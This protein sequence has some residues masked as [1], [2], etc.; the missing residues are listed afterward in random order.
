MTTEEGLNREIPPLAGRSGLWLALSAMMGA[1]A[2][3]FMIWQHN[4]RT[5]ERHLRQ[6]FDTQV[7]LVRADLTTR[8]AGYTQTLRGA[9]AL[10]AA[11]REVSREEWR[12]Y[13]AGLRLEQNYP[14]IQALAFARSVSDDELP[15]LIDEVRQSGVPDFAVRPPGRRDRY[16]VNVFAEPYTGLNPKALGYD[17]WQDADRRETMERAQA[18]GEPMITTRTTL[19]VDDQT[20]PVPAF[21]M[22]FPVARKPGGEVFGYVLSPFRMPALMKDWLKHR[23]GDISLSIHDGPVRSPENLYYSSHGDA[24]AAGAR[25]VHEE[26]IVVGGRPWT[27]RYASRPQLEVHGNVGALAQVLAGGLLSSLLLFATIWSLAGTRDR[28]LRLAREMTQSLR[29]SEERWKFALEGAGDGVWDWNIQTGEALFSRRWKEM[30]GFAENEIGNTSSEWSSRVHPED[31]P[32]AMAAVQAHIDGKTPSA[33]VEFRMR[34]KDGSWLWTLGRGMVVSRDADGRAVRLVGTNTDIAERKRAEQSLRIAAITF[35]CQEGMMITDAEQ[36]ILRVNQA[37]TEITGYEGE[38]VIGKTPRLLSSGRHD[39]TFY[40][41]M[42]ESIQRS[43]S[44]RG[45]I[46]NR[47]KGGEVYPEWLSITAVKGG[48][49]NVT[50]YVGTFAD[51]TMRKA[52]EEEIRNLAFYDPL[53]RLPNRRLMF[54]RLRQALSSSARRERHG[55]LIL[56]DLDD[57]KT[58]NDTLGH[59]VGDKF[60][61][62]VASRIQACIRDGDTVAR[63]GGD[64]FVVILEDLDAEALAAMQAESVAVKILAALNQPYLLDIAL[65]GEE[66]NARTYQ[67][68]ASIGITL[69]R[70][71][72]I[73]VDEL[74]KRAD[75][76]MYQAK[77]AG[78]NTLRFY[79]PQMQAAVALR[80]ALDADL[81]SA[82]RDGEFLLHYQPQV[83]CDGRVTGA[84]A[85]VRWRHPRRGLTYP[86]EFIPQAE[87]NGLILPLGHWVLTTACS[88]L[89]DWARQEATAHLTLAVNVSARQ[90]RQKDF[91]GQ[92]L[93]TIR[94]AGADPRKLKLEVTESLLLHDVEDIIIKMTA[95]KAEGVSFSL[96]DFGTGYSSLSYLKQLPLGQLKIDQS[97]VR[98]L[99]IDSN[100]AAIA[101]TIIALAMSLGLPVIAEGVETEAQ[102]EFLARLGCQA[103]QGYLFGKP[104]AAA[105]VLKGKPIAGG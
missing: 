15:A 73:S 104:G 21:I 51:I 54:D 78:R 44:W 81:R 12:E 26:T 37:F 56:F 97:F 6:E 64:E 40:K 4:Q 34:C 23:S 20:N 1:L 47:R 50:H 100:D 69:F 99:M 102:R 72:S 42:W 105:D 52:V 29:E 46:W 63:L 77:A 30:I 95:L 90:F 79:D 98:D 85:L 92:V 65:A 71:Q 36:V 57:F 76:A 27:L 5:V 41:A 101:G 83:D 55:A 68:S 3:T 8:M 18:A 49:G 91:V 80:A 39:V 25:F 53:T 28:A 10:F 43:G 17:M 2:L 13:V 88:Q 84:E 66:T 22:Y 70:D 86:N 61:V 62:E 48:D 24:D 11:S 31:L 58:L 38:E 82:L 16:V 67:C 96:D 33:E 59:D 32:R 9:A 35:E 45:E 93:T 14:A 87:I 19:R 89:A 60:L 103:Y 94:A 7:A 74:M 75:T